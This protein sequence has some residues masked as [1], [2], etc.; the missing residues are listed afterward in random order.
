MFSL[1][2]PFGDQNFLETFAEPPVRHSSRRSRGSGSVVDHT[3]RNSAVQQT[4]VTLAPI[5][6]GVDVGIGDT[7]QLHVSRAHAQSVSR[8]RKSHR[9]RVQLRHSG[10]EYNEVVFSPTG[11]AKFNRVVGRRWCQTLATA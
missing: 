11:V 4:N 1:G 9:H 8:L 5:D 10:P 7:I 6:S 2:E 3:Y